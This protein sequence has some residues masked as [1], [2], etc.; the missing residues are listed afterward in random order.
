MWAVDTKTGKRRLELQMKVCGESEGLDMIGTLGGELH[1]L[2]APSDRA[3]RSPSGRA[4]RCCTSRRPRVGRGLRV[5]VLKVKARDAAGPGGGQGAG[6]TA[7]P[8]AGGRAR[9]LRGRER[10]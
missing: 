7:R 9:E 6:D 4:A 3:A 1:W 8:A 5:K 2:I 10:P